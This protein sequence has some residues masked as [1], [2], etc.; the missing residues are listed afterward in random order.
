MN[1]TA[2]QNQRLASIKESAV[3]KVARETGVP[4]GELWNRFVKDIEKSGDVP[5]N[6][7]Q[8]ERRLRALAKG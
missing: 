7:S 3:P 8:A 5:S 1:L 4:E 2:S 6:I